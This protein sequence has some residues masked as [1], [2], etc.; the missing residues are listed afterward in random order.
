MSRL[1]AEMS[2]KALELGIPLAA[3][4][5]LLVSERPL[6]GPDRASQGGA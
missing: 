5:L 1:A 2:R 6:A 4:G 3:H